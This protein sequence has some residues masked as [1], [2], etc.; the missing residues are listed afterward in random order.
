M[1]ASDKIIINQLESK[2]ATKTQLSNHVVA[3]KT[4]PTNQ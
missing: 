4:Q 1:S 3:S 2:Y